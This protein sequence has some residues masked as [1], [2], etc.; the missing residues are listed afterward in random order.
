MTIQMTI[1]GLGQ[2]GASIG[3]ALAPKSDIFRRVGHDRNLET[4][5]RAQ[6]MG[7]VEHVAI[8]LPSAVREADIVILAVPADQLRP[9]LEVIARARQSRKTCRW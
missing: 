3:L 1:V 9:T 6:K 5:R 4:A 8:N 2:V 7:A